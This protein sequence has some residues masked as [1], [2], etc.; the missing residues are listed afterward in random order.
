L[1]YQF[2]TWGKQPGLRAFYGAVCAVAG[3]RLPVLRDVKQIER[4]QVVVRRHLNQGGALVVDAVIVNLAE[5]PQ[6]FPELKLR[7]TAINGTLVAERR[8]QPREYLAG[9]ISAESLMA[10]QTP[11]HI[12]LEIQDPG[13]DGVNYSLTVH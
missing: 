2:D 1:W 11:V 10:P 8:F 9:E 6:P 13:E 5:F 3:C 7:F 4:R 12:E